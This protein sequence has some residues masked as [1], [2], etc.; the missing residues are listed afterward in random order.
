LSTNDVWIH[1]DDILAEV[2]AFV[3]TAVVD[4]LERLAEVRAEI[5][6]TSPLG[7]IDAADLPW[8]E[9]KLEYWE[10][11]SA[12]V[13]GR[14]PVELSR[15]GAKSYGVE[16]PAA[17]CVCR[18]RGSIRRVLIHEISHIYDAV[19]NYPAACAANG[20]GDDR[21]H[22]LTSWL[23]PGDLD[24]FAYSDDD[25]LDSL[26]ALSRTLREWLPLRRP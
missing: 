25:S 26:L 4:G 3:R 16:V 20:P 13:L 2:P 18:D 14:A 9:I 10:R 6:R 15:D 12:I 1:N 11:D 8:V 17:V 22:L 5:A 19:A 21:V 24:N 23:G 7:A